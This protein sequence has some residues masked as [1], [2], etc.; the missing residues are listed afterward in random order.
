MCALEIDAMTADDN[1][2]DGPTV[3]RWLQNSTFE[4]I[5]AVLFGYRANMIQGDGA[6]TQENI[7]EFVEVNRVTMELMGRL[8]LSPLGRIGAMETE[9]WD[10]FVS[11]MDRQSDVSQD[12]LEDLL[13]RIDQGLGDLQA[14]NIFQG[15]LS[16][17]KLDILAL[18]FNDWLL[19]CVV[20][21]S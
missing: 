12:L 13:A 4:A 2:V 5:F 20:F 17:S 16:V 9:E 21:A 19:A 18:T 3:V 7:R 8:R 1:T 6:H 14:N 10:R 15:T 11:G